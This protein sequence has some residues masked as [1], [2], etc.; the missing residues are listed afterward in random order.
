MIGGIAAGLDRAARVQLGRGISDPDR[1]RGAVPA[2]AG[3]A[4]RG[5]R[6]A[7]RA[8]RARGR[9]ARADRASRLRSIELD[10]RVFNWIVGRAAGRERAVLARRRCR[11]P[12]SSPSCCSPTTTSSSRRARSS[13]RSFFGVAQDHGDARRPVPRCCS[14]APRC[15]AASASATTD[16]N[17]VDRP[18]GADDRTT[19]T[20]PPSRRRFDAVRAR[21]AGPIRFAVIGLGTGTLACRAEPGDTVH[22]YEIDPRHHPHRARSEAV[23]LPVGVPAGRAD[24]ARRRAAHARR[25]AR[26]R[27]DLIIV[28]AFILRRHPDPSDH[29]RGDG[30]LSRQAQ[31]A[32]HR[33]R[34]TSR[35]GISSSPRWSPASPPP[36][37]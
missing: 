28:D 22:Y 16:G 30:D 6:Q 21:I 31:P 32:R 25:C 18:A 13:V 17:P 27:Y 2:G 11:L 15:T 23:Q 29:A 33:G 9:G 24:H 36:T 5:R 34:C 19:T 8:R 20:A 1:A 26:R 37:A 10:E 14:T 4:A 35:T 3:A 12:R 7:I